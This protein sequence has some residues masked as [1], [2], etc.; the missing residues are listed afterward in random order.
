[1]KRRLRRQSGE[2]AAISG[3]LD[4]HRRSAVRSLKDLLRNPT[5]TLM[6]LLVIGITLALPAS[7]LSLLQ[8]GN[9]VAGSQPNIPSLSM[10]LK[11]GISDEKALT[12]TATLEQR[13]GIERIELLT[14]GDAMQEFREYSGFGDALDALEENPLPHVLLLQLDSGMTQ[15]SLEKLIEDLDALPETASID[16]DQ[17]WIERLQAISL[18]LRRIIEAV[19]LGLALAVML[20]IGN[21]I[22][23]EILNRKEEIEVSRLVGGSNAFIRRPFLYTGLAYGFFGALLAWMLVSLLLIIVNGPLGRLA[24]LYGASVSIAFFGAQA[25]VILMPVGI[26]LGLAGAW[27]AVSRHL[28][29]IKPE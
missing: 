10:F 2:P 23:L 18:T 27:L 25:L 14:S 11:S 13:P 1:V 6:T 26:L 17:G 5:A 21:T 3:F 16:Y 12:L 29:A 22:R 7:L 20:I 9:S 15:V 19:G 28:S 8:L 24:E 4:Q